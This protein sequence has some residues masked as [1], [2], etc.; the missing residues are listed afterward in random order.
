MKKKCSNKF[1]GGKWRQAY[2]IDFTEVAVYD[3][4][5]DKACGDLHFTYNLRSRSRGG[6]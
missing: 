1:E 4:L 2:R 5:K 6:L 3:Q